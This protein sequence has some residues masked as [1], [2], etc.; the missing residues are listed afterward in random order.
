MKK[1][2]KSILLLILVLVF[3]VGNF[4]I[5]KS[6]NWM[7]NDEEHIFFVNNSI[8]NSKMKKKFITIDDVREAIMTLNSEKL[9]HKQLKKFHLFRRQISEEVKSKDVSMLDFSRVPDT[10]FNGVHVVPNPV[11]SLGNALDY[12]ASATITKAHATP[13]IG[14]QLKIL[15]QLDG[16][17]KALFKPKWYSTNEVIQGEIYSGKDR[18]T[19]EILGFYIGLLL[20]LRR[21]PLV[22]GRIVDLS[23][24]ILPVASTS[25]KNTFLK[26]GTNICFYGVCYYCHRKDLVCGDGSQ[27]EG[28][29]VRW[30]PAS[31]KIGKFR[32]PWARTY[33]KK[34][35][36]KWETN[37]NFCDYYK[38]NSTYSKWLPD[39]VDA[40]IFD[41][42]L[43]NGDRHDMEFAMDYPDAK[44]LL[45]DNGKGLRNAEDHLDI[46]APLF[47]CCIVNRE[48]FL[49]DFLRKII[50]DRSATSDEAVRQVLCS[51]LVS[52]KIVRPSCE[53]LCLSCWLDNWGHNT[54]KL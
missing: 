31:V 17:V 14:T 8:H 53:P 16:N 48:T 12:L 23:K 46:L 4:I 34:K 11:D 39:I 52:L 45:L 33:S 2:G 21:S 30:L 15:L 42:I 10:W 19:S 38:S 13:R 18:H 50:P 43:G 35:K 51:R 47:Q 7:E 22:A 27:M 37:P 32:S 40:A 26:N 3:Y 29:V 28:A 44:I 36:A 1:L 6:L 5:I 54:G 41:F 20:G 25:L 49:D 9:D 24:E